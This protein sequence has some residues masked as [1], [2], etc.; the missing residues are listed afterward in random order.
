MKQYETGLRG[1]ALA[2]QYLLNHGMI[3]LC[4]RF[5]GGD[6]E[7]DLIMQ[8]AAAVVFVEVKSRPSSRTGDG[9]LAITPGKQRRMLHA[10]QAY[11]MER[12]DFTLQVRFDIVEITRD[13]ILHIPNAFI[14]KV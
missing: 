6:G 12:N 2:E 7:I 1:E 4:R 5:R 14:P 11:L 9:L 10:A 13:G 8:D 3:L